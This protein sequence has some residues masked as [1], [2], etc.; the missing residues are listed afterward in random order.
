ML[1]KTSCK[2]LLS[3]EERDMDLV[4][5][6][7]T[8]RNDLVQINATVQIFSKQRAKSSKL[9]FDRIRGV[10][11]NKDHLCRNITKVEFESHQSYRDIVD[12]GFLCMHLIPVILNATK[13][14]Y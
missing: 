13:Q 9:E 5:P 1:L 10:L 11:H 14:L 7:E 8:P 4:E 3:E 12:G 6:S 2:G